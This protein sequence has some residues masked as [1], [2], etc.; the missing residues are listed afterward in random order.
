MN[1]AQ[2]QARQIYNLA[3]D[4][5]PVNHQSNRVQAAK[6]LRALGLADAELLIERALVDRSS[7]LIALAIERHNTRT[8]SAT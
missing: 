8:R 5:R 7:H 2:L 3:V 1:A 4:P 6:Q